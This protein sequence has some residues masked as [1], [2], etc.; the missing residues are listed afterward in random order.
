MKLHDVL[1]SPSQVFNIKE[2]FYRSKISIKIKGMN[3][4]EKLQIEYF[5]FDVLG[6]KLFISPPQYSS[7]Y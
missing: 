1:D 7:Y 2:K 6:P 5:K 3:S 4:S